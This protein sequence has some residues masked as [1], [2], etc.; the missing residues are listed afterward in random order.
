MSSSAPASSAEADLAE[1]GHFITVEGG[2]G[3]GKSTQVGLLVAALER[4]GRAVLRTREPGGTAGAEAIRQLLVNGMVE[5]WD[6]IGEALLVNAARRDHLVKAVWPALAAGRWIVSDRFADSTLAYQGH[7]GGVD[8]AQLAALHRFVAGDFRPDLTLILDLPVE[9]GL[10]R[11]KSR[12]GT[13]DRFERK[14]AGFHEK[15]RAGFLAIAKAEPERCAVVD[16]SGGVEDV[17]AAVLSAVRERF[18]IA[19]T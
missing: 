7:A 10:A 13:E 6:A 9:L 19:L 3:S 17:H 5:R 1:P 14:G 16:A 2:E 11:A 12:S 4:S 18:G 15:I 8:R